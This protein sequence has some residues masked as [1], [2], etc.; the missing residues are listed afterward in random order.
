MTQADFSVVYQGDLMTLGT[1][2]R[3]GYTIET[4]AP[5]D[6]NGKGSRFS[7]TDLLCVSLASCMMTIMGIKAQQD[8]IP[9]QGTTI[10]IKKKMKDTPRRVGGIEITFQFDPSQQFSDK[11]KIILQRAADTCPVKYS[12]HP[13]IELDVKFEW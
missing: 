10:L 2:L 12:I 5:V 1:H 11:H 3:S 6:N 7:P 8:N 4:D 9:L 13:E